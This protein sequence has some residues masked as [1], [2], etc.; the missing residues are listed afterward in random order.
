[1][2]L[3]G[4]LQAHLVVEVVPQQVDDLER[5]VVGVAHVLQEDVE[6]LVAQKVGG[7]GELGEAVV[8]GQRLRQ[9]LDA[10]C[11][12]SRRRASN[13]AEE[14]QQAEEGISLKTNEEI[15]SEEEE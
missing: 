3:R 12:Q 14:T 2:I 8:A 13:P 10:A 15:G 6:G 5:A 9:H 7:E 11:L 4:Q 1:M